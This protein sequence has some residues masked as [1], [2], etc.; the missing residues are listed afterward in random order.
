MLDTSE[1]IACIVGIGA[2]VVLVGYIIKDG[3][4]SAPDPEPTIEQVEDITRK[5]EINAYI[6]D[7]LMTGKPISEA[8][9]QLFYQIH[10][11]PFEVEYERR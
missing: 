6:L 4:E 1:I 11:G 3:H 7:R 10:K 8:Y 5:L 2:M 9:I